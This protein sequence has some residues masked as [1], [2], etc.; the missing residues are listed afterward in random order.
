MLLARLVL[1]VALLSLLLGGCS[2]DSDGLQAISGTVIVDGAP[3]QS[4]SISFQPTEGQASSSG[5]VITNG[6]YTVPRETGLLAGNYRV[7]ISAPMPGTVDKGIEH[8]L[9]GEAPPLAKDLIP[10]EWN[11][12]SAHFIDVK[13]GGSNSFPFEIS[14]KAGAKSK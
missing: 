3:V 2:D 14:T 6:K 13:K 9:P 7:A 11:S 8:A 4:G 5:A 1:A 12:A 10:P